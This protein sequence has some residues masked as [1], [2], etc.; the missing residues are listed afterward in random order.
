MRAKRL[1]CVLCRD[2]QFRYACAHLLA[3]S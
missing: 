3:C 2:R 1:L